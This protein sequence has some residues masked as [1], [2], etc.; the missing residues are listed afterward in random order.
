MSTS[1]HRFRERRA[2]VIESLEDRRLLSAGAVLASTGTLTITG[3]AQ[4]EI[5][6]IAREAADT[7][8]L[9]VTLNGTTQTFALA[10]VQGI[11]VN[12]GAGS[13]DVEVI[14]L[15]A[16]IN[17]PVTM[18]GGDGNDTLVGGSGNDSIL[19]QAGDDTLAGEAGND[20]L[21]GG[22]GTDQL[23]DSG[24]GNTFIQDSP[25]V[26]TGTGTGGTGSTGSTGTGSGDSGSTGTDSGQTEKPA[27]VK[28]AKKAKKP[29]KVHVAKPKRVKAPKAHGAAKA[30]H[31]KA[32]D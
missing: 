12:A 22:A 6:R 27:K 10:A 28:K 3:T 31:A 4:K 16:P 17:I 11:V 5:V 29:K 18:F 24:S 1:A 25:T 2:V 7:S 26:P 8:K 15:N 20:A 19:G 23:I 14:E 30:A 32:G 9:D 13:D 21:V